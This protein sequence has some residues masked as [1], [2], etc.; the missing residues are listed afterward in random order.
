MILPHACSRTNG[1]RARRRGLAAVELAF[2]LP[3]LVFATMAA[4]D[5]AR[6]TYAQITLQNCARNGALYEFYKAAGYAVPS[7][8]TSLSAAVQADSGGLT[9]T[10]PGTAN[11]NTNPYSPKSGSNNYVTVTVQCNFTLLTLG[12][13]DSFPSIGQTL[14]LSRSASMP[15]PASTATV[16]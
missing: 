10:V 14:T 2:L 7:G 11:G 8:W 13:D 15:M 12:S 6:I 3:L 5:F 1:R 4:V 16:P 9:V